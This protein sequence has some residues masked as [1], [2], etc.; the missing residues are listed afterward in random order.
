[1]RKTVIWLSGGGKSYCVKT[2][3]GYSFKVHLSNTQQITLFCALIVLSWIWRQK[4]QARG[5]D[6]FA[7]QSSLIIITDA[8][9]RR[10][11][12]YLL[13]HFVVSDWKEK[14]DEFGL[15]INEAG[16]T[17]LKDRNSLT[18]YF[19]SVGIITF[20]VLTCFHFSSFSCINMAN[21][22]IHSNFMYGGLDGWMNGRMDDWLTN[23]Q[24]DRQTETDK[25]YK[26]PVYSPLCWHKVF[27]SICQIDFLLCTTAD[28]WLLS[29]VSAVTN[30][31]L[32]I[33]AQQTKHKKRCKIPQSLRA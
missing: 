19:N 13:S 24:T 32:C 31:D 22:H 29:A 20:A 3:L 27:Y 9:R 16:S 5:Q 23:R 6:V 25:I 2:G 33:W 7:S 30:P 28:A 10:E 1:M 26:H 18:E 11:V 12:L 15:Q 14:C 4:K 17:Q 8:S 21:M